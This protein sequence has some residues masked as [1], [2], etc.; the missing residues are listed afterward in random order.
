V[1]C[2]FFVGL[3]S[4]FSCLASI[5]VMPHK[6]LSQLTRWP[7]ILAGSVLLLILLGTATIR[8]S[9]RGWQVDQEIDSLSRQADALEGRNKRLTEIAQALQSPERLEVEARKRLGNQQ[10]G[11][12]IVVLDGFAATGTWS[13]DMQLDV[14]PEAPPEPV[15]NPQQW[16]RYFFH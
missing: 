6:I 13:S 7:L 3:P 1:E 11:E 2:E 4:R 15:S 5:Q 9:Y 14:V 10:P 12:H 16:Y 8:E